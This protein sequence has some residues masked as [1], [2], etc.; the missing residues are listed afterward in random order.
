MTHLRFYLTVKVTTAGSICIKAAGSMTITGNYHFRNRDLSPTLGRWISQDPIGFEG[1]PWNLYEYVHGRPNLH[2]DPFGLE[3]CGLSVWVYTGS[4]CVED[5]VW[6]AAM[7][8]A[9]GAIADSSFGVSLSADFYGGPV[10]F[11]GGGEVMQVFFNPITGEYAGNFVQVS[12]GVG[13]GFG[14]GADFEVTFS[15]TGSPNDLAFGPTVYVEIDTPWGDAGYHQGS[16]YEG[17]SLGYG[18]G[19]GGGIG[20]GVNYGSGG[21]ESLNGFGGNLW[22]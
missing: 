21:P 12:G 10:I 15:P 22:W 1:S 9:G 18:P 3:A 7:D 13:F 2:L 8:A 19:I 17:Y 14:C 20:F 16:D 5:N 4:W 6:E 11:E